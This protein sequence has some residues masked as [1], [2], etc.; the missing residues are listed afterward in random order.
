[1]RIDAHVY[2]DDMYSIKFLYTRNKSREH[3]LKNFTRLDHRPT[4]SSLDFQERTLQE[5]SQCY[6][7]DSGSSHLVGLYFAFKDKSSN[8]FG[9]CHQQIYLEDK[10][11]NHIFG[12]ATGKSTAS[13]YLNGLQFFWYKICPT[14]SRVTFC[15]NH[16]PYR[17]DANAFY[18]D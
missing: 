9:S 18:Q 5:I 1:M 4:L 14:Q 15:A 7:N 10:F 11:S 12:Y 8:L 17:L 16:N 3:T 2:H 6:R 13:S